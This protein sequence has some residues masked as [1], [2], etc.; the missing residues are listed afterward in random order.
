L[1]RWDHPPDAGPWVRTASFEISILFRMVG[2]VG[3]EPT[4]A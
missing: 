4:K 2:E 1:P 3:L